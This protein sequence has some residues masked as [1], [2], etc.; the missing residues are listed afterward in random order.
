VIDLAEGTKSQ[1]SRGT[2]WVRRPIGKPASVFL[3]SRLPG[4]NTFNQQLAEA[5]NILYRAFVHV[6]A[7]LGGLFITSV[8]GFLAF[9]NLMGG[10]LSVAGVLLAILA[11][12][13]GLESW[14]QTLKLNLKQDNAD[15]GHEPE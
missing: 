15:A 12:V 7:V 14:R 4:R 13:A 1:A 10:G 6:V 9:L 8:I 3:E 11:P 5:I 2:W